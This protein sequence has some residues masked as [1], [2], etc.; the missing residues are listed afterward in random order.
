MRNVQPALIVLSRPVQFEGHLALL[1]GLALPLYRATAFLQAL[2]LALRQRGD[3]SRLKNVVVQIAVDIESLLL[4][5]GTVVER[6]P[7]LVHQVD[8][9][10][11]KR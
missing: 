6:A 5:S 10:D 9:Q 7:Q 1:A 8:E 11:G 3:N 4:Q 2:P